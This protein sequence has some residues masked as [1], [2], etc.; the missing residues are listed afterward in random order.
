[1]IAAGLLFYLYFVE[2]RRLFLLVLF[3]I[4]GNNLA[5]WARRGRLK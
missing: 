5:A 4:G 3:M 1:M 2:D